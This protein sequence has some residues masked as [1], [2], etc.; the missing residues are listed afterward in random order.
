MNCC[1]LV[2]TSALILLTSVL[3]AIQWSRNVVQDWRVF[4]YVNFPL[5]SFVSLP[6]Q[7]QGTNRGL[8]SYFLL[9]LYF[10]TISARIPEIVKTAS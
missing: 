3:Y 10:G 2:A 7:A 1:H 4:R 5:P 9:G 6:L 8:G